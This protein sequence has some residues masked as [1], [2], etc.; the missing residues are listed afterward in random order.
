MLENRILDRVRKMLALANDS[1][2]TEGERD[3]ALR[4][5]YNLLAKHNLTEEDVKRSGQQPADEER[6]D[7]SFTSWSQPWARTVFRAVAKLFFCNY[8]TGGKYSSTKMRHI[9]VGKVSNATT[10][11]LM[12]EYLVTSIL[13]EC[14]KLYR[15][16]LSPQSRA[17]ATGA[18]DRIYWRVDALIREQGEATPGTALVL[19]NVYTQEKQGND[20]FA[21]AAWGEL[22][23]GKSRERAKVDRDAYRAGSEFGAKASL[24]A[25]LG[26]EEDVLKQL[27]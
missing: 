23:A 2:A 10:A 5:A 7:N 14:R 9:Y 15:E 6:I 13:R 22:K 12:G 16:N 20:A 8:Y 17:F 24:N 19:A 3:N 18:A 4:M 1:A 25:Q 27:T 21:L 11:A 26:T